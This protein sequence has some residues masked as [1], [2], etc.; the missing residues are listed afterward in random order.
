MKIV[1]KFEVCNE[2]SD[3]KEDPREVELSS[4]TPVFHNPVSVEKH[5]SK[6]TW[7]SFQVAAA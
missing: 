2:G 7:K 4:R 6:D 3:E 5:V 1:M